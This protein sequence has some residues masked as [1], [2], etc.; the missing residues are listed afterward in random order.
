M[1]FFFVAIF[2]NTVA[3]F[4]LFLE[5]IFKIY[6]FIHKIHASFGVGKLRP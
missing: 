2:N 1:T 4:Q 3:Q 6:G 5:K